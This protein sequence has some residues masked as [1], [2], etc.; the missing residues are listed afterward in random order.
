MHSDS[1][2]AG[3]L[4]L[5]VPVHTR[6]IHFKQSLSPYKM[7]FIEPY[8]HQIEL[9]VSENGTH[10][11]IMTTESTQLINYGEKLWLNE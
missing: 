9:T 7:M 4:Q 6:V 11:N 2:H 5:Q 8:A 10:D 1:L 3:N